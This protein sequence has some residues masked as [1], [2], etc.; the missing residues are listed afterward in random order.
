MTKKE[1][2]VIFRSSLE[3]EVIR[4]WNIKYMDL[5]RDTKENREKGA[6]KTVKVNKEE[7]KQT[8]SPALRC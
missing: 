3:I 4:M 7:N 6:I 5:L 8:N 1:K 2:N